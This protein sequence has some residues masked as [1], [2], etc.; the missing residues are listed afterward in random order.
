MMKRT[1]T[2]L[3]MLVAAL[4]G[5]RP[6]AQAQTCAAPT[7]VRVSSVGSPGN[8]TAVVSFTPS[9][10]AL[11]Y[12]VRYFWIGDSTAADTVSVSTTT[13]PVTLTGLRTGPGAVYRLAVVSSCAGGSAA[14]SP[15]AWFAVGGSGGPGSTG[16]G[17]VTGLF[18]S[19]STSSATL[20]FA[21]VAGAVSYTIRYRV[22][23]DS[24]WTTT[25][26]TGTS[27]TLTGLAP[28]TQL[29]ATIVTNCAGGT[30]VAVYA[31][32]G[33]APLPVSCGQVSNVQVTAVDD[34][35]AIVSF[36]TVA[37]AIRYTVRCYLAST[38]VTARLIT[39]AGSPVRLS[40]LTPG[41]AY[42]VD[43]TATCGNGATLAIVR[44]SF[45][46]TNT[47]AAPCGTVTN[48]V[49]TA[50]SATTA[51]MSFTPGAGNTSFHITYYASPDSL[52]VNTNASPVTLTGLVPGRT[53]TVRITSMCT[54]GGNTGYNATAAPITFAFRGALASAAALGAGI[55]SVFPNPAHRA[56]S[57][58]LPAVPGAAQARLTLLNAL[59][60]AVRAVAIP[61][62]ATG[63]TR[64]ALDLS[65]VAPGLYTL[66]VQA[67]AQ[68]ASQ[69][70]VVE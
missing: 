5:L 53:Y 7:N 41:R 38:G 67:G 46:T 23:G 52:W 55:F 54:G 15:W 18:G 69:R 64:A 28:D 21:P 51:T 26:I 10:T 31:T 68:A 14:T 34:S 47:N 66:R 24:T 50:S 63:E 60:Q 16:C 58:V 30:S 39:T 56:A 11:S 36:G 44:G 57:L 65:G 2:F 6:M 9:A 13:S 62:A 37:G 45:A 43:I 1:A 4:L 33:S 32:F 70:L 17:T 42:L 20:G 49:M 25:T 35:T 59:G 40:G 22:V 19:G 12:T 61:L 29:Q 8:N 27:L 3:I 48:V